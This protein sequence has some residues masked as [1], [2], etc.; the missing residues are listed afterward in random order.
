MSAESAMAK[1]VPSNK[2][3]DVHRPIEEDR[4]PENDRA[5]DYSTLNLMD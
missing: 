5:G 1:E 4:V 2:A 3:A